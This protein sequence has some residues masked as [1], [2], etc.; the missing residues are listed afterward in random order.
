MSSMSAC[1]RGGAGVGTWE[2]SLRTPFF[3]RLTG[4]ESK[5]TVDPPKSDPGPTEV[6]HYRS[7]GGQGVF[8]VE[9]VCHDVILGGGSGVD[10]MSVGEL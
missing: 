4:Y 1:V 6:I 9:H 5:P 8:Q 3:I 7:W 10:T 2:D